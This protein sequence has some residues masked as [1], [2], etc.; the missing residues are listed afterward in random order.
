MATP[1]YK[2]QFD[3]MVK[4]NKV[5]FDSL[6]ITNKDS[7]EYKDLKQKLL[8]IIRKNEDILCSKTENTHYSNFSTNLADKFQAEIIAQYPE[9]YSA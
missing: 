2:K 5:L 4:N 3:E 1:K 8:R 7:E 6:K 9:I